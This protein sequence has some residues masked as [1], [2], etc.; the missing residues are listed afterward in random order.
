M[1]GICKLA[2][3]NGLFDSI[4]LKRRDANR[5]NRI[6]DLRLQSEYSIKAE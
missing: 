6:I 5:P 1:R 2:F 4:Y 3:F